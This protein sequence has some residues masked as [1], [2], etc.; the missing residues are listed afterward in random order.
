MIIS[1]LKIFKKIIL[2]K[3]NKKNKREERKMSKSKTRENYMLLSVTI[4]ASI[5]AIV[6]GIITIVMT[7]HDRQ[8][9][10]GVLRGVISFIIGICLVLF[11]LGR[12]VCELDIKKQMSERANRFLYD[13]AFSVVQN[14]DP[15]SQ[16]KFLEEMASSVKG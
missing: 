5:A 6:Y 10:Y 14:L 2:L 15:E 8:P 12:D 4:I 7:K 3:Y 11:V 1:P 16:Q 13:R 9:L